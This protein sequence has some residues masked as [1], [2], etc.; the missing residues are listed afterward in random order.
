MKFQTA[1]FFSLLAV[2]RAS[3]IGAGHAAHAHHVARQVAAVGG[4]SASVPA[5]GAVTTNAAAAPT[6]VVLTTTAFTT[7]TAIPPLSLISSG[8]ASES[9]L[10]L[11]A[12]YTPGAH[13]PKVSGAPP[14][15]ATCTSARTR[16]L[17]RS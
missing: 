5:A 14:L 13:P 15:P 11:T 3:S 17:S 6:P 9:S 16:L 1:T 8:M 12:T 4:S 7:G 2:A 10:P